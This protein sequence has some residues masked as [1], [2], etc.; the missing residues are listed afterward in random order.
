MAKFEQKLQELELQESELSVACKNLIKD[1]RFGIS[2]IPLLE[3]ENDGGELDKDIDELKSELDELDNQIVKKI[4]WF[5]N[6]KD[7]ID[8]LKENLKKRGRPSKKDATATATPNAT[9]TATPTPTPNPTPTPTPTQIV[10]DQPKKKGIGFGTI[11]LL[12]GG[13]ILGVSL[14]KNRN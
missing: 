7:S 13:T 14:L 11:L 6:H 3:E 4:N 8:G 9:A 1:Y 5:N 12:L 2:R 10:A